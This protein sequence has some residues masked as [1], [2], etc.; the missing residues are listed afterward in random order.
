MASAISLNTAVIFIIHSITWR[1]ILLQKQNGNSFLDW[2]TSVGWIKI[3]DSSPKAWLMHLLFPWCQ[4]PLFWSLW[5]IVSEFIPSEKMFC[6]TWSKWQCD[7][8]LEMLQADDCIVDV[9][10]LLVLDLLRRIGIT[11]WRVKI[12]WC[13]TYACSANR[14]YV[15]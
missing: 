7:Q 14:A 6:S 8:H 1:P 12:R 13:G 10:P 2:K 9:F 11:S 4:S 3:T 15:N 5:P